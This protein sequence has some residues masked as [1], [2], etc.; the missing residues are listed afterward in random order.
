MEL[1]SREAKA[2]FVSLIECKMITDA[3]HFGHDGHWSIDCYYCNRLHSALIFESEFEGP[4]FRL[5]FAPYGYLVVDLL[6][7]HYHGFLP[8]DSIGEGVGEDAY[9]A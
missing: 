6:R 1:T 5:N 2:F 7:E 8:V 9:H 3:L 4:D